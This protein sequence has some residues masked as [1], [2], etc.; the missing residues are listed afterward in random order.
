MRKLGKR[1]MALLLAIG[2]VLLSTA[3][4]TEAT[5]LQVEFLGMYAASTGDYTT[6]QI[7]GEF[8]VMQ[9]GQEVGTIKVTDFGSDPITL[10][11]TGNVQLI[12]VSETMPAE[13]ILSDSYT[14]AITSGRVNKAVVAVMTDTG[15]FT[16]Q[17]GAASSFELLN[18]DDEAVM[19]FATDENGEYVLPTAIAA[20]VYILRMTDTSAKSGLWKDKLIKID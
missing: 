6:V 2:L 10:S 20:G 5:M 3:A 7:T 18:T 17:A 1:L 19:T 11:G 12:P 14:I 15:L 16:V 8:T 4:A 13:A 9:G